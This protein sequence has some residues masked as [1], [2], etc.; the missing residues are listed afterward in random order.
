ME[1]ANNQ[2]SHETTWEKG[3]FL[4]NEF[5]KETD[6]AAAILSVSLLE[7][8]L[9]TL[10]KSHLAPTTTSEDELFDQNNAPVSTFNS[11]IQL[12]FRLG[13]ISAKFTQNFNIIRKMRNDFAHNVYGSSFNTGRIKDFLES[14]VSSSQ[15]VSE[16]YKKGRNLFP[17][18]SRGRIVSEM[19]NPRGNFLMIIGMMI[20]TLED[21]T[22]ESFKNQIIPAPQEWL[23][24]KDLSS[25]FSKR[26]EDKTKIKQQQIEQKNSNNKEIINLQTPETKTHQQDLQ[27]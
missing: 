11:K 26:A 12:A 8:T 4:I 14:L 19:I 7:N 6:R 17:E 24:N 3:D 1:N 18:G 22:T 5:S 23:H 25:L 9:T 20:Q 10:L 15:S 16:V 21:K 13:L 27:N 2:S